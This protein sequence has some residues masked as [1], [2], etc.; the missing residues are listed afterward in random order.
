MEK[1]MSLM[2]KTEIFES[3]CCSPASVLS[4]VAH[5]E[6]SQFC[7]ELVTSAIF[8]LYQDIVNTCFQLQTQIYQQQ[9]KKIVQQVWAVVRDSDALVKHSCVKCQVSIVRLVS[10]VSS[11]GMPRGDLMEMRDPPPLLSYYS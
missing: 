3:V 2:F 11:L 7:Q 5:L 4:L 8:T 1:K 9:I 10:S 6:Q